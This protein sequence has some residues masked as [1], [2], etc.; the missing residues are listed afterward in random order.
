MC[1]PCD[2]EPINPHNNTR[3]RLKCADRYRGKSVRDKEKFSVVKKKHKK[4]MLR[5]ICQH[6]IMEIILDD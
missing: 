4:K 5:K 1:R 6:H 3:K 2:H